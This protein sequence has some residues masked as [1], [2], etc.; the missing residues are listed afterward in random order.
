MDQICKRKSRVDEIDG[1]FCAV[2][3]EA[4][5]YSVE[6]SKGKRAAKEVL[7]GTEECI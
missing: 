3:C 4:K 2:G 7:S 5:V 6:S 1:I